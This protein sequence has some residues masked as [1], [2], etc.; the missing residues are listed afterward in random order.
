MSVTFKNIEV[1]Y[2]ESGEN[3]KIGESRICSASG[4]PCA[5]KYAWSRKL[6]HFFLDYSFQFSPYSDLKIQLKSWMERQSTM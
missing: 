4:D 5:V 3:R 2:V 1:V 6:S